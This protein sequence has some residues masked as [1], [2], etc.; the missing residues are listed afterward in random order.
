MFFWPIKQGLRE[1]E[2]EIEQDQK[3]E[4]ERHR[5][6]QEVY[7]SSNILKEMLLLNKSGHMPTF[8]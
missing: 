2:R 8:L 3:R 5:E 7:T 1:F 6:D 4:G